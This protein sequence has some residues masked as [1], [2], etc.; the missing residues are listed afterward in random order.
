MKRQVIQNVLNL[1]GISGMALIDGRN[2]PFFFGPDISLNSHQ[3][4]ALA[5]GIQQVVET[6][7]AHFDTFTFRFANQL[8]HIYKLDQG[9]ILLVLITD[10]MPL[11][12]YRT[13][14]GQ[15]KATLVE[16]PHNAVST[17]RLLAGCVTLGGAST[18]SGAAAPP[19]EPTAPKRGTLTP[20]C[21]E[22]IAALNHLSDGAIQYLGKTMVI[23]TWKQ[24]RPAHPWLEQ[25]EIQKDAHFTVTAD[26]KAPLTAEQQQW[27]KD[28]VT[29]FLGRG[30]RT[31]R[32]FQ[33]LATGQTLT[34][35]EK[36]LLLELSSS[37]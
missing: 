12:D 21:H 37:S 29:A 25:F 27:I 18:I 30:G 19:L 11:A 24:S 23:N 33:T 14:I 31:I 3:Q 6:T 13:A 26:G 7:P 36:G 2:R 35:Q 34:P 1:P 28:W 9:L 16:A 10:Q 8:A 22:V 32:N 20:S 17:F 4:D 5:Q 15:L